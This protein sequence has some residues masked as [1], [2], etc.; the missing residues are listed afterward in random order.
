MTE[1]NAP[2]LLPIV[3]AS[4]TE[5]VVDIEQREFRK[6]DN[7][8]MLSTGHSETGRQILKK[9]LGQQRDSFG[10]DKAM[11]PNNDMIEHDRSGNGVP[12]ALC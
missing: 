3:K 6:F 8:L 1:D 11:I 4:V 10:L 12:A 7:Q 2:W 9:C 5:Y